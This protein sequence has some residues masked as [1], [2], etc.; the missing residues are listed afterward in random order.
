[1]QK[2]EVVTDI[3]KRTGITKTDIM[4][5]LEAFF[6]QVKSTLK[7]GEYIYIRGFGTFMIK[8]RAQKTGRDIKKNVAV[9]IPEQHIPFFKPSKRFKQIVAKNKAAG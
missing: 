1:M 4:V 5:V 3:S 2:R 9:A 6:E 8:K 7:N